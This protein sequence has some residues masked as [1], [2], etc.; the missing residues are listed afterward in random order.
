MKTVLLKIAILITAIVLMA[1]GSQKSLAPFAVPE[2]WPEVRYDFSKNPFSEAKFQLGRHLFYDPL[3]SRD[4]SISCASCHLQATAFTH[5]D[6]DLS[7]G[8]DGR[9]GT[10]NSSAIVNAAWANTFMWDG[11]VNHLDVQALA[12]LESP[13]E[14]DE[15]LVQVVAKLQASEKYRSL[16]QKAFGENGITGQHTLLALSQFVL[17]L[18][19]WNS[20]YDRVMR[21][22][23]GIVFSGQEENGLRLFRQHC[24]SCHTE[25]LFTNHEFE[26]NG[27]PLDTTLQDYG[28]MKRSG[29]SSDSLK[30]KVPSLRNIQFSYP[31]MHDGRFKKLSEVLR[32]Y[33]GGVQAGPTLSEKINPDL[34]LTK[35]EQVDIVAFLL[36][37]TDKEFLF[38]PRYGYPREYSSN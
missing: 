9:I 14:M 7:H 20:K 18:N 21:K 35:E 23:P 17:Q 13:V 4:S 5:V 6:H 25:P 3:L 16:F 33:A 22:E 12:P 37:L 8:I 30:F 11:S 19:S 27:L 2:G 10:R 38:N 29:Q 32:H 28:K 31:Y 34:I 15:K 24:G 1:A 36:T 26:N